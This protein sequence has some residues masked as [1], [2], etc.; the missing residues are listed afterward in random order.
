MLRMPARLLV[1]LLSPI[2]SLVL[3]QVA[4][5]AL[6]EADWRSA[7]DRLLTVDTKKPRGQ[8]TYRGLA[9]GR[10]RDAKLS[11]SDS[12]PSCVREPPP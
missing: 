12:K 5:S 1:L 6:V 2:L 11:G 4:Q 8:T 10:A 9:G 7:G 3:P